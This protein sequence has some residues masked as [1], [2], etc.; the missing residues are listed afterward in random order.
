MKE[1]NSQ[2]HMK[3][4]H[5]YRLGSHI[6]QIGPELFVLFV[7]LI[8][9]KCCYSSIDRTAYVSTLTAEKQHI[10]KFELHLIEQ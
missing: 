2:K 9:A 1:L 5:I 3:Q 8:T 6:V 7:I 10:M 4:T